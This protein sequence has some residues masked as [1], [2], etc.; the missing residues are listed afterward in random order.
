MAGAIVFRRALRPAGTGPVNVP[1]QRPGGRPATS[2]VP[3]G[4]PAPDQK[5]QG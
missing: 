2:N 3:G 5:I 4:S 1:G